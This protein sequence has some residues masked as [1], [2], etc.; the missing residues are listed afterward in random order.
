MTYSEE[1]SVTRT[2]TVKGN[3]RFYFLAAAFFAT[4]FFA[5]ACFFAGTFFLAAFFVGILHL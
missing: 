3:S 5:G 4:F 2:E 1:G